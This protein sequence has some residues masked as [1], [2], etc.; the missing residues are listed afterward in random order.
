MSIVYRCRDP[1]IGRTVAVKVLTVAE[2][3]RFLQEARA[4]GSLRHENIVTIFDYG[5]F[6]DRPF[7]VMEYIEGATMAEL[8]ERRTPIPLARKLKLLV[9]LAGALDYAHSFGIVHRDI[10]PANLMIDAH[11]MLKILDFGIAR[12]LESPMT[13]AGDIIG[14][15]N[16][17][18]PEQLDGR[19]VD[20]RTD[21]FA[22]GL[23]MYE[24]LS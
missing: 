24:L 22:V 20:R 7:I 10:K 19:P 4:V 3:E 1:R 8:L 14:T 12:M 23:T 13:R 21:V 15:P 5:D 16:Y 2:D 9:D 17:M 6:E 11:G 18:S